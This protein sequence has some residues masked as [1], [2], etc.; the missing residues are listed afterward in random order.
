MEETST[1]SG[2]LPLIIPVV[3]GVAGVALGYFWGK[4][5]GYVAATEATWDDDLVSMIEGVL[6][7]R[8]ADK[9]NDYAPPSE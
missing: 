4:L 6:A 3:V 7:D 8:K 2:L 9:A 1:L 5:K